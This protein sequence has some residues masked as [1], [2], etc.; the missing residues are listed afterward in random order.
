MGQRR[1]SPHQGIVPDGDLGENLGRRRRRVRDIDRPVSS[2]IENT[3]VNEFVLG[4]VTK[5]SGVLID[6]LLVG[7]WRLRVVITPAQPSVAGQPIEIPP[8]LFDVLAMVPLRT[9]ETEHALLEDR[10]DAVPER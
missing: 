1:E 7:E 10:V 4:F 9:G 3:G 8:V 2:M 5:T 6:Q